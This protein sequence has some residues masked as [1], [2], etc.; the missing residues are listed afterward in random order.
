[1]A[2]PTSRLVVPRVDG[3]KEEPGSV[4]RDLTSYGDVFSP[5]A[6]ISKG[7]EL[8]FDFNPVDEAKKLLGGN[9]EEYAQCAKAWESLGNFCE[10]L[11][12]NLESGNKALDATWSGNAADSAY[13]YVDTLADDVA[14]MKE[15]FD[16]LKEQYERVTE[17]VWHAAEA[18]GDLLGGILDLALMAAITAAA[19]ASTSFTLFGPVI[20]AGAVAGEVVEMINLWG[21]LTTLI[22]E[23]QSVVSGSVGTVVQLTRFHAANMQKFPLPGSGYD[24]PAV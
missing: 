14:A 1:M 19:G 6:M 3:D 24:N 5:S 13:V 7:L 10:D 2:E 20:A 18:C 21:K 8:A 16:D 22:A 4:Y 15:S 12:K 23:V 17:A 11:S 9:W